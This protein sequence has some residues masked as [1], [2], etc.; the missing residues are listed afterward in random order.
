M[1]RAAVNAE[2]TAAA[3]LAWLA[4]QA[5]AGATTAP[6]KSE[7]CLDEAASAEDPDGGS[8]VPDVP[9]L[10]VPAMAPAVGQDIGVTQPA[11]RAEAAHRTVP[12]RLADT[13]WLHHRLAV[14]GTAEQL[15]AFRRA[16]VGAGIIPWQ[17][18]LDRLEEDLFH[19]LVAP[20]PPQPRMLSVAGARVLAGQ[21]RE[22]AGRRHE[23]AVA[24]V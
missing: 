20:P 12:M 7:G 8:G 14:I 3:L 4:T 22:A 6:A 9:T 10:D 18:D 15:A 16:A 23:R 11:A 5:R 2:A 19:L 13:D 17:I 21:L 24:R 1:M